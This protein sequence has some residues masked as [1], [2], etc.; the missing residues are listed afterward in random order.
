MYGTSDV[1]PGLGFILSLL[2]NNDLDEFITVS[3]TSC[4]QVS[5][6]MQQ[7][8]E[9]DETTE[10]AQLQLKQQIV[11]KDQ[12]IQT[13]QREKEKLRQE[14]V[15]K[16][17]VIHNIQSEKEGLMQQLATLR[18]HVQENALQLA[19]PEQLLGCPTRRSLSQHAEDSWCSDVT[20]LLLLFYI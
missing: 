14:I 9:K 4:M 19:L 5:H 7:S 6:L 13:L 1:Q 16:D 15:E 20:V 18:Q 11:Q 2:F 10:A 17:R 3:S 12:I 8:A